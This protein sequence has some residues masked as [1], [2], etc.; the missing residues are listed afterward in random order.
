MNYQTDLR[1]IRKQ[2]TFRLS[3]KFFGKAPDGTELGFTNVSMVIDGKPFFAISGECHYSRVPEQS[4][5]DTILKMKAGGLNIISAYVFWNHHEEVEGHFRFDGRRNLRG[6]VELCAKHGM[7]AI[8]RIGP[9]DHG[10]VRNGGLPDWLYGKPFEVR[11]CSEGFL[12]CTRQFYRAVAQ[13][14]KGLLYK[15]GGPVIAVQ[16]E[17][18]YMHSASPWEMT[19]GVSNE[20]LTAGKDGRAYMLALKEIARE[21]GIITPFYTCTGWGGAA[22][23]VDEMMPLWGGYAFWPWMFYGGDY[24]HPATPEYLYRDNHNNEVPETYNFKPCYEPESLPYACC[25]IGGGMQNYYNYRF[26][27]PYA[28]VDAMANIKLGSGCSFFGYYMYKGG[29]NPHGQTTPFLNECQCPKISYDYQAPIGEFGQLRPSYFRLRT[30]HLF[31]QHFGAELSSMVTVLPEGAGEIDP[32]DQGSLR[33][34]VRTDG[35]SGYLFLNNYQDHAQCMPKEHETVTLTLP[36]GQVCF[37]NFSLAAEESAILPFHMDLDGLLL[38]HAAAQP[39]VVIRRPGE[40]V[41]FFFTPAGMNT[42]YVFQ[43]GKTIAVHRGENRVITEQA[44]ERTIRIVTLTREESFHFYLYKAQDGETI[45]FL[46]GDPVMI[47]G[48]QL[49]AERQESR[50]I[51]V[52]P[53]SCGT[54]RYI[55]PIRECLEK[56][57]ECGRKTIREILL[58]VDYSGNIG[59]LFDPAGTLIA[60]NFCNEAVWET[61][62]KGAGVLE[63]KAL[64][65]LITPR[66][67]EVRVDVSSTMAGRQETAQ[68]EFAQ[69]RSVSLAFI[70]QTVLDAAGNAADVR[71]LLEQAGMRVL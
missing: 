53:V 3:E 39:L 70:T 16:I 8:L 65:L 2:Q 62:L 4:W 44:G 32:A 59:S 28:S 48:T 43:G 46:S 22:T 67:E 27:L 14:I 58:R 38:D 56:D 69:L 68:N 15:D 61:G 37:R 23:P 60:D 6:F 17:N 50:E 20:W 40:S 71:E 52:T 49:I 66:K 45:A 35:K 21:E 29:S 11:S 31:L 42:E 24:T 57:G 64:T 13:Q 51:P 1:K 10:E 33:Y 18:E 7:M 34:V 63:E 36:D 19:T 55:L 54:H 41:F 30:T 12:H 5:E 26:Q 25:E 47:N 9:F